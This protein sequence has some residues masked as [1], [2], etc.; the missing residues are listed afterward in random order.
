MIAMMAGPLV[1]VDVAPGMAAGVPESALGLP[2][3][4]FAGQP[5]AAANKIQRRRQ[6]PHR[7]AKQRVQEQ[8]RVRRPGRSPR[9]VKSPAGK[10]PPIGTF[11]ELRGGGCLVQSCGEPL[12]RHWTVND[13][14]SEQGT[15]LTVTVTSF[16]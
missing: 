13:L 4:A 16:A 11:A 3:A 14:P 7:A 12:G 8:N 1:A 9:C 5:H 2:A 10:A 6:G 15:S